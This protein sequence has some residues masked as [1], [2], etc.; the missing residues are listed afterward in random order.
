MSQP[1]APLAL[2]PGWEEKFDAQRGVPYFV[3]HNTRATHWELPANVLAQM[4]ANAAAASAV[5]A[6][7]YGG[8]GMSAAPQVDV[9]GIKN[10]IEVHKRSMEQVGR[11]PCSSS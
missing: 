1:A 6:S 3:D 10:S 5:S 7:P 8:G 4:Q 9:T 2:L 11:W